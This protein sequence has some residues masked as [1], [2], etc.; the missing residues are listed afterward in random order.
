[1]A[2]DL[3]HPGAGAAPPAPRLLNL[4]NLLSLL[5]ILIVPLLVVA[6]LTETRFAGKEYWALGLFVLAAVTDF[7]DGYLARRRNQVTPLGKLL[8]PAADKILT[9]SALI[10][11]VALEIA[12]AWI[13]VVIL[14]REFAVSAIRSLAAAEGVVLAAI[15]SAK[16]KTSLQMLA[17]S[18]L[19]LALRHRGLEPAAIVLLWA[20]LVA[21][22]V[23]GVEYFVRHAPRLLG[24]RR[25]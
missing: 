12:P 21:S 11:L 18:V 7:F 22:V 4:P 25:G 14:A 5:R 9:S 23:S 13:V 24:R 3:E 6:L 19:I 8:D 20:A 17:I 16:L 15:A 10:S 2:S 1:M